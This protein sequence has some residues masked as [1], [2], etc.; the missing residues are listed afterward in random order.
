MRLDQLGLPALIALWLGPQALLGLLAH[1]DQLDQ[2]A[3]I[4]Q[5]LDQLALLVPLG[6]KALKDQQ[7]AMVLIVQ[8]LD[9]LAQHQT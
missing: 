2:Q 9:Q 6:L 8:L 7:A 3:A 4:A 5:S 1:R